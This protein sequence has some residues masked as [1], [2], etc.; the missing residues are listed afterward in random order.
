MVEEKEWYTL[1]PDRI[2]EEIRER[3]T[4]KSQMVGSL[5][6]SILMD[7]IMKLRHIYHEKTGKFHYP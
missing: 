7:E 4:L 3:T 2:A 1:S 5:Y 6:P